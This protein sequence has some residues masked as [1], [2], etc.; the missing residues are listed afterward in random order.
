MDQLYHNVEMLIPLQLG[1]EIV[2]TSVCTTQL[3]VINYGLS[4]LQ[5]HI[6]LLLLVL[7]VAPE[8]NL[9]VR[10]YPYQQRIT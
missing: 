10:G 3:K 6:V 1:Q 7:Q 5:Q 2:I 9:L 8:R 4:Q